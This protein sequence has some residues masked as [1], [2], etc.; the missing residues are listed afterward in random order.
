MS[1][2]PYIPQSPPS[3][4]SLA[5]RI[6]N[7]PPTFWLLLSLPAIPILSGFFS[8]DYKHALHPTGEFAARFMI[9]S[10]MLTPLMMLFP[11][12]HVIRWLM[13][14]RRHIGVAAFGY[15]L[16]HVAAFVLHEGTL[17]KILS[18][19]FEFKNLL[20]LAAILI[21]LPLAV[22]SNNLSLRAM[23]PTWKLMQRIVYVAAL[24]VLVHWL[25]VSKDMGGAIVHFVPLALLE[26]YR[27]GRNFKWW[28]FRF[29]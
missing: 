14:R 23:G 21:F 18:E 11:K 5:A 19:L 15:A 10:M 7:A 9:I 6:W 4:P 8:G 16:L 12:V 13:K 3:K 2:T 20:G 29:A 26:I 24:A 1:V 17:P 27:I 28:S 22:T 25:L